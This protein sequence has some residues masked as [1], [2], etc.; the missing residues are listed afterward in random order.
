MVWIV[1]GGGGTEWHKEMSILAAFVFESGL[2][3]RLLCNDEIDC[4]DK[5][6]IELMNWMDGGGGPRR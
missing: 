2:L 4:S 1:R 3:W 5:T 6:E